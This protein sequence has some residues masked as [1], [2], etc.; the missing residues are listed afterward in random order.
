M[1]L[2]IED[3]SI[4]PGANSYVTA[5]EIIE[6]A[7]ER[8]VSIVTGSPASPIPE[9]VDVLAIKAMDFLMLYD[10]KWQ[11]YVADSDQDLAW[12]RKAVYVHGQRIASNVIPLRIKRAQMALAMEVHNGT[13]LIPGGSISGEAFVTRE[14][15]GPIETEYSEAVY[16]GSNAAVGLPPYMAGIMAFITPYLSTG[17]RVVTVRV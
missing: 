12:P 10:D 4:V 17:G 13:I 1:T 9:S 8:G 11:G 14:K 5:E 7:E 6:Y 3:G 15:I 2:I 16:M